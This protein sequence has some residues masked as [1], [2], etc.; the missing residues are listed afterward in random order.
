MPFTSSVAQ[1]R[2]LRADVIVLDVRQEQAD[3]RK[4]PGIKRND[5]PGHPQLMGDAAGMQRPRA[6][7]GEQHELAQVVPAHGGDRLDRLLHFHVDDADDALRRL[8]GSK[9]ERACDLGFDCAARLGCVEPHP[10][11][12]EAILAQITQDQVAIGDGRH[13]AAA[14]VAG[15]PRHGAGALRPDLQRPEAV[16]LRHRATAGAHGVDVQH[17]HR[18]VAFRNL[19]ARREQRLAVLDQRH[20]A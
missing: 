15:R 2:Q 20:V 19:S 9:A 8:D 14:P 1:R 11:A 16:D 7:E 12:E 17:G 13:F 6:A 4:Y 5:D 10:P 3:R 18:E